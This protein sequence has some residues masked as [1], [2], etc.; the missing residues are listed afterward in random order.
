MLLL[1]I[2]H[3]VSHLSV[4]HL[5][6]LVIVIYLSHNRST[7]GSACPDDSHSDIQSVSHQAPSTCYCLQS[8]DKHTTALK[9]IQ[10]YKYI[11]WSDWMCSH[12]YLLGFQDESMQTLRN[13]MFVIVF[14]SSGI[15]LFILFPITERSYT[16]IFKAL[17][18]RTFHAAYGYILC[19]VILLSL[20]SNMLESIC[21][22]H[23]I[24]TY[25]KK[26]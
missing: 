1:I 11:L 13:C 18:W 23:N 15:A 20:Y 9:T 8:C 22:A 5:V 24:C 14:S 19:V 17:W 6:I 3:V 26:Y 4:S 10:E 2:V 12:Y 21:P 7:K 25:P 16:P